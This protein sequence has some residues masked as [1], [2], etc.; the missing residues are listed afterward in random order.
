MSRGLRYIP[1]SAKMPC[2]RKSKAVPY[3]LVEFGAVNGGDVA[4]VRF[5]AG[6]K[7]ARV[8]LAKACEI[9]EA[10]APK[11]KKC[12]NRRVT[13]RQLRLSF[14]RKRSSCAVMEAHQ[15]PSSA[16]VSAIQADHEIMPPNPS[17]KESLPSAWLKLPKGELK[18]GDELPLSNSAPTAET[19][20]GLNSSDNEHENPNCLHLSTSTSAEEHLHDAS[21]A[22]MSKL[23]R[24]PCTLEKRGSV[25]EQAP[26]QG[27]SV[28]NKGA[29]PPPATPR[30][31]PKEVAAAATP[32][33]IPRSLSL[34][35]F[36]L[37]DGP[38]GL[39]RAHDYREGL[40]RDAGGT[41]L[42]AATSSCKTNTLSTPT[43][44]SK[45]RRAP[46][47]GGFCRQ[48]DNDV[49]VHTAA[50]DSS[51]PK[52][53]KICGG[54]DHVPIGCS[55]LVDLTFCSFSSSDVSGV[56]QNESQES[57]DADSED[58][59]PLSMLMDRQNSQQASLT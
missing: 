33:K 35:G 22:E 7:H 2:R 47:L 50:Q 8:S 46:S 14:F 28:Y 20:Y 12:S 44:L 31:A 25:H 56:V 34:G 59:L 5:P 1:L 27:S 26:M 54:L 13:R 53:P 9:L 55:N 48:E 41:L 58:D 57:A 11:K 52:K 30:K 16:E 19:H 15:R 49:V 21:R 17:E 40:L 38:H 39:V 23:H 6:K 32:L 45:R 24:V 4:P 43:N 3:V 51:T 10:R 37:P 29:M 18:F 42:P 36:C